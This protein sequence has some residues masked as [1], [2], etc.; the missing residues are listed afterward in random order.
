MAILCHLLKIALSYEYLNLISF[1]NNGNT[2]A[3]ESAG[4]LTPGGKG[5]GPKTSTQTAVRNIRD[6][7]RTQG[8]F[9]PTAFVCAYC[10]REPLWQ[11]SLVETGTAEEVTLPLASLRDHRRCQEYRDADQ[12]IPLPF[13]RMLQ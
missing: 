13:S 7:M 8:L 11:Q 4:P 3:L 9:V 12:W 10:S 1:A 6:R 2:A 5:A